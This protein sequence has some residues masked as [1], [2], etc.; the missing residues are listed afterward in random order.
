[1]TVTEGDLIKVVVE[2]AFP[3]AGLVL[4]IFEYVFGGLDRDDDDLMDDIATEFTTGWGDRWADLASNEAEL[5][6]VH[7]YKI[8]QIGAVIA[9]LGE[10]LVNLFGAQ[11]SSVLPAGNAAYLQAYTTI[12]RVLGKKYVAGLSEFTTESGLLTP[13]ALAD[14]GLLLV[15]YLLPVVL[16]GGGTLFGGVTSSKTGQFELFD[17]TG[18]IRVEPAYQRRRKQG[19][20]A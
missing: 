20:G 12:P 7:G 8:D 6:S 4:N 18:L 15:D 9:D 19:V 10:K 16:A 14:L 3:G 17:E 11:A 5:V 2:Y 13:V 1:M